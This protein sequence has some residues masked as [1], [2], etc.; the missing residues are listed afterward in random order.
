MVITS[1]T[2]RNKLM[3]DND[4]ELASRCKKYIFDRY[5]EYESD[6]QD[7]L[8][9]NTDVSNSS[10][11]RKLE[12]IHELDKLAFG[13]E[14]TG[15][16]LHEQF[17]ADVLTDRDRIIRTLQKQCRIFR[18]LYKILDGEKN[19]ETGYACADTVEMIYPD[20][21]QCIKR[22]ESIDSSAYSREQ[23]LLTD[24]RCKYS[25]IPIDE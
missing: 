24:A 17:I 14:N 13:T 10:S 2:A 22:L 7:L 19:S 6:I 5:E 12:E 11:F 16:L 9:S 20:H 18:R 23:R 25:I 1:L 3:I 4:K 8:S 15:Y 21:L